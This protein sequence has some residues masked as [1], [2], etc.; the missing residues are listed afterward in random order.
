MGYYYGGD[1]QTR[2]VIG[3]KKDLPTIEDARREFDRILSQTPGFTVLPAR[4][5]T[6]QAIGGLLN[7]LAH[8]AGIEHVHPHALR[9][10]M[11]CHMLQSGAGIRAIQELLGHERL[12][13]TMLYTHLTAEDLKRVHEKC[14]PHEQKPGGSNDEE[15]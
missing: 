7:R 3:R 4:A 2:I 14:H 9:R 6:P 11:A 13:T 1:T 12:G 15:K 5:Y 10:T 8:R